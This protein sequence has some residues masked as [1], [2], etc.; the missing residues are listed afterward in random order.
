MK[1]DSI[2]D[3]CVCKENGVEYTVVGVWFDFRWLVS[4][5]GKLDGYDPFLVV[6]HTDSGTQVILSDSESTIGTAINL[7]EPSAP[8]PSF[9]FRGSCLQEAQ[10]TGKPQRTG[11][12][13]Y[14]PN[15][16]NRN[17]VN[18]EVAQRF[19]DDWTE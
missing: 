14:L 6:S 2:G 11:S 7:V 13:V 3:V 18:S 8:I 12:V 15:G 16:S 10:K 19:I 9:E 4:S 1:L 17:F 5:D